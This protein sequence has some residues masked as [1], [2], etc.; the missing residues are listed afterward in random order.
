[1]TVGNV[2]Q[3]Y[4]NVTSSVQG[5]SEIDDGFSTILENTC[6]QIGF[7][8]RVDTVSSSITE[9]SDRAQ[10]Y[11]EELKERFGDTDF[12]IADFT[13][14]EQARELLKRGT[15]YYNCVL[16]PE[17]LE[18]MAANEDVRVKYEAVIEQ[19]N[20][21]I[22]TIKEELLSSGVQDVDSFGFM[23]IDGCVKYFAS[24]VRDD[25]TYEISAETIEELIYQLKNPDTSEYD[26]HEE[27]YE[28]LA[29]G[30]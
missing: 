26:I 22:D 16:T 4:A 21:D 28:R 3:N 1:M 12:I 5:T 8:R 29:V 19:A 6:S 10:D 2:A 20:Q 24:I 30:M 18:E 23:I 17:L 11:L 14:E 25:N 13:T 9:L 27:Y 15:G 7:S